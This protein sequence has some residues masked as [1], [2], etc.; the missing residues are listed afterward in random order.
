MGNSTAT[1]TRSRQARE[2]KPL[3]I[4][5]LLAAG[6]KHPKF[7]FLVWLEAE[8]NRATVKRLAMRA[9]RAKR[10][11]ELAVNALCAAQAHFD[12]SV[13]KAVQVCNERGLLL[14]CW[15]G[16]RAMDGVEVAA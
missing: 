6:A 8:Q 5:L 14:L 15:E 4:G 1:G 7:W 2:V 3:P 10:P 9:M 13:E 11:D 12:Y 16:T